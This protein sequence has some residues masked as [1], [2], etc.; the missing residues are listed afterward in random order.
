MLLL[1]GGVIQSIGNHLYPR[2]FGQKVAARKLAVDLANDVGFSCLMACWLHNFRPHS[3]E[4]V[5]GHKKLK[6][7]FFDNKTT[8]KVPENC[9]FQHKMLKMLYTAPK[10]DLIDL[11]TIKN[12]QFRNFFVLLTEMRI[13]RPL[14][15]FAISKMAL[16]GNSVSLCSDFYFTVEWACLCHRVKIKLTGTNLT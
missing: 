8:Q 2:H 12:R 5:L 10:P 15:H 9:P 13:P 4:T 11:W 16:Y 3:A 1:D 14:A 6:W 7:V